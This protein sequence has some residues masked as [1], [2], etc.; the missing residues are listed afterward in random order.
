MIASTS[1][2]YSLKW[3]VETLSDRPE[4][5]L[6]LSGGRTLEV[7]RLDYKV[8]EMKDRALVPDAH[9]ERVLCRSCLWN[10]LLLKSDL[11]LVMWRPSE[12]PVEIRFT[13]HRAR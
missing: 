9:P 3:L 8:K 6:S 2:C 13:R 12:N 4:G 11:A 1:V 10:L 5:L 7:L